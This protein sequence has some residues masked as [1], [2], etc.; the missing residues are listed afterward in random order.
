MIFSENRFPPSDQVRGQAFSGSCSGAASG[1][2]DQLDDDQQDHR[3]DAGVDEGGDDA[4]PDHDHAPD[5]RTPPAGDDRADDADDDI[6]NEPNP[7]ALDDH[8]RKPAS[9]RADDN[10]DD[11]TL[12]HGVSPFPSPGKGRTIMCVTHPTQSVLRHYDHKTSRPICQR[13]PC[14]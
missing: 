10:P 12:N 6:A 13:L 8:A 9:N 4:A 3:A 5:L 11:E 2:F 14:A 1:S 7:A